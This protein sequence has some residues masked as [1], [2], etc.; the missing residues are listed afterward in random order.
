M[1][2]YLNSETPPPIM[3]GTPPPPEWR[4]PMIDW[5]RPPWNRWAFQ[6][7]RKLLPTAPVP[8]GDHVRPLEEAAA[9]I[10]GITF[11][12]GTG[13]T[14]VAEWI[15]RTYTDGFLV[16]MDGRII[17]ES[18]WNGMSHGSLH[19]MQ[20]V[21]KSITATA[22][23]PLIEEGL[24]DP[25][26]LVTDVL[27][28]LATTAWAGATLGQVM[29][30]TSGVRF[31]E[32]DYANRM[33]DIGKMDVASGWKPVP[34]GYEHVDWPASVHDQIL[35]LTTAEAAHGTRFEYR[36]IETD[37]LAHAME[38][39]TGQRLPEI[40]SDRLWKPLGAESEAYFTVD[41]SGY[42]LACGGFNAG[43]RDLARFGQLYLDGGMVAGRQVIPHAWIADVQGGDHGHFNDHGRDYFPNGCYR[44]QFW[45][46]DRDRQG[47]FC[48]GVFG[49][50]IYVSPERGMVF[51]KLS[52]WPDATNPQRMKDTV[53][54]FH[55]IAGYFGR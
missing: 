5:D 18:Y 42:A 32:S 27:P 9:P 30:M 6:H 23:A 48:L 7:M 50:C 46:E 14:T 28:E 12:T 20:S 53:A 35:S 2:S 33:S 19:L 49:Q 21:S 16:L 39:V 54:A 22:A 29:D 4:V 1:N 11:D 34:P 43:L 25:Y 47:H 26:A 8:R 37:V 55:A 45:I 40:V 52:T 24:L 17:H 51:V 3:V 15:D 38:R 13:P 44:N 41:P 31:D 36:S 10:E